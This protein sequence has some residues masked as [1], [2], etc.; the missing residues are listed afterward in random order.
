VGVIKEHESTEGNE[1]DR[2]YVGLTDLDLDFIEDDVT[3]ARVFLYLFYK[4]I[5]VMKDLMNNYIAAKNNAKRFSL[6]GS[7]CSPQVS[8]LVG[9]I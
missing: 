6:G 2:E 1:K 7:N 5:V 4:D 8:L 3:F 9:W